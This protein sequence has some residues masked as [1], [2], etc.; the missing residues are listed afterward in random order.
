ML[1]STFSTAKLL[2][3]AFPVLTYSVPGA[4]V[5]LAVD[6]SDSHVGAIL[7]HCLHG[8]WSPLAFFSKMLSSTE[9]KYSAYDRELLAAYSPIRHFRFLLEA[10]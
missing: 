7:Q 9:S 8:S 1:D 6:A 2:L 4:A 3:F 5:S 10:S